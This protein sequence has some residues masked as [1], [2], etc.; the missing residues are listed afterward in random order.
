MNQFTLPGALQAKE[1]VNLRKGTKNNICS[2]D[3]VHTRPATSFR[4][5]EHHVPVNTV[6]SE[7]VATQL[8]D[9]HENKI[10]GIHEAIGT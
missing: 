10:T 3:I 5:T 4:S 1:I 9:T 8:L 2:K 6:R 7:Q